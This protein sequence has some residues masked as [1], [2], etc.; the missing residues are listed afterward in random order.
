MGSGRIRFALFVFDSSAAVSAIVGGIAVATNVDNLPREWL[1]GSPFGD[2]ATPGAILAIVVGGTAALAAAATAAA[3]RVGAPASVFAGLVLMS[4]IVGE[5]LVLN[6][7]SAS[8][9]P[10]SLVEPIYFLVGLA[11]AVLGLVLWRRGRR[12]SAAD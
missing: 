2:Y 6:Q 5:L 3:P 4:W 10:R 8:T 7:N 12:S 9:N 11:M 1:V